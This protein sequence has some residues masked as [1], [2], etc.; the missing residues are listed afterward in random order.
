MV[1]ALFVYDN[2]YTVY[3]LASTT[4]E[5]VVMGDKSEERRACMLQSYS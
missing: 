2:I 3:L 5:T 4:Y 1:P